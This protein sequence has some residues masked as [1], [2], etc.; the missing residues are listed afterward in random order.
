MEIKVDQMEQRSWIEID[1]DQ[2]KKIMISI[3]Q[4]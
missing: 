3:S 1:L 2:I 4:G